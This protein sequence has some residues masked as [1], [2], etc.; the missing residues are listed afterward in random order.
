MIPSETDRLSRLVHC[1]AVY[2]NNKK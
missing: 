1:A 2:R